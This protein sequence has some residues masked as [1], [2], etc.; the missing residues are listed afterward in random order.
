MFKNPFF[1]PYILPWSQ[2]WELMGNL[3]RQRPEWQF[4]QV[5]VDA[6]ADYRISLVGMASNGGFAIDDIKLF[7]GSCSREY[8]ERGKAVTGV[9]CD[10]GN[11]C[12]MCCFCT[13]ND[14]YF[15][16]LSNLSR[17]SHNMVNGW[18]LNTWQDI[19][20]IRDA[21][22]RATVTTKPQVNNYFPSNSRHYTD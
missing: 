22:S 15:E 8:L 6:S 18:E 11:D 12:T 14:L 21:I 9:E 2:L 7:P 16:T 5:E 3:G 17:G 13:N 10:C 19:K 20:V 4:G 1:F